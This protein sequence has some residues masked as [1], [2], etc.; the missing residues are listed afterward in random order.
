MSFEINIV[1]VGQESSIEYEGKSGLCLFNEI[2][3]K[4][5]NKD[6]I[7]RYHTIWP[8]F[9]YISGI[10]YS[11]MTYEDSGPW[12]FPIC[13]SDFKVPHSVGIAFPFLPVEV[14][15]N[16]TGLII[17]EK[18]IPDIFEVVSLLIEDSPKKT[19]LFQTRYQDGDFEVMLGTFRKSDFLKKLQAEQLLFNVC[20][21]V[22]ED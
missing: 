16:L 8:V 10:L 18:F 22:T 1:S 13:T 19:I 3:E 6:Y 12:G 7:G 11:L 15:E 20:Y 2:V 4:D 5:Y 21:L 17:K 9:S 14:A